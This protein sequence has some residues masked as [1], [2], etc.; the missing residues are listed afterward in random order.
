MLSNQKTDRP[1]SENGRSFL[2]PFLRLD[3]EKLP[4]YSGEFVVGEI[5]PRQELPQ[6]ELLPQQEPHQPAEP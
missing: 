3:K 2:L 5:I 1:P 4:R 6:R